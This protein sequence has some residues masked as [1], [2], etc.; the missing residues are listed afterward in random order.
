MNQIVIV[1]GGFDSQMKRYW[2]APFSKMPNPSITVAQWQNCT[3]NL[4]PESQT[5]IRVNNPMKHSHF[6]DIMTT[7]FTRN[8]FKI[9]E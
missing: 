6:R 7:S 2:V 4:H 3:N 9:S 8:F 1:A 5:I